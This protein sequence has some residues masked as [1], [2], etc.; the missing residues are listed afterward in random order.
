M[1]DIVKKIQSVRRRFVKSRHINEIFEKYI[2]DLHSFLNVKT[3][4]VLKRDT[5]KISKGLHAYLWISCGLRRF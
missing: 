2:F 3:S 1:Y 4:T 5:V